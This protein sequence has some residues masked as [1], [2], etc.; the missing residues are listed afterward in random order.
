MSFIK[1]FGSWL[2]ER[3]VTSEEAGA[4]V[5]SDAEWVRNVSGIKERRFAKDEESVSDMAAWAG[6]DCLHRAGFPA[7]SLGMVIVASS[8]F[9]RCFPGPAAETAL[10]LGIPGR[11]ALDVTMASAGSLFAL[12]LARRLTNPV[13]PVLVIGAEKMSSVVTREPR[14]KG[15]AIL[16]GDGAGAA[17]VMPD[18]GSLELLDTELASD[19]TYAADLFLDPYKPLFM[20]GRSVIMQ[21]S[22]KVPAV[23]RTVLHRHDLAPAEVASFLMHQANQ[24]LIVKIAAALKVPAERFYSNIARYGN[25]SSASMLIAAAEWSRETPQLKKGTPVVF[26]AFGAGFHWGAVLARA[27]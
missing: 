23:I 24:N 9:D 16:F 17:L 13:G 18:S 7:S 1:E 12:A 8:S 11:P 2:P 15:V 19:G 6:L 22:R 10:K 14:E 26:A 20:N 5:G 27:V 25:T 21:A 4:W 3:V